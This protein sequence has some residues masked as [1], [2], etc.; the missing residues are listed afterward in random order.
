MIAEETWNGSAWAPARQYVNG[1]QYIDERVVMRDV[2]GGGVDHYYLLEE[3]YSV[4]GMAASNGRLKEAVVYDTYGEARIYQW[5]AG[6]V[7]RNGTVT[8][9][10]GS[11][12]TAV[13]A[14]LGQAEPLYDL[15]LDGGNVDNDDVAIV[16]GQAN[17]TAQLAT[18]SSFGNPYLFTGRPSDTL[19]VEEGRFRRIQ[20][21]RNR[22][23]DPHHGRWFQRDP[24]GYVDGS[25]LYEYA[26]SLPIDLVDP[27]GTSIYLDPR[28]MFPGSDPETLTLSG[29]DPE[30]EVVST[31]V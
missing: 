8:T 2:A 9:G 22:M 13:Q 16:T 30:E 21:N 3:L 1:T 24:L 12:E 28:P 26:Q 18:Y 15:D 5:K 31:P 14:H 27:D 17:E 11:D 6:D 23:Y 7:D 25:N 20:D 10:T 4:A 29:V 19:L